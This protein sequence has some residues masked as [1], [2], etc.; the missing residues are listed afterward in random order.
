MNPSSDMEQCTPAERDAEHRAEPDRQ[1]DVGG[2]QR[3]APPRRERVRFGLLVAAAV[4]S[5][6]AR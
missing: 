5:A 1:Q 4:M 3:S 6:A 2:V